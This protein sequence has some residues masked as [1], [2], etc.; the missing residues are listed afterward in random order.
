[1]PTF[2]LSALYVE[3]PAQL[4][5]YEVDARLSDRGSAERAVRDGAAR[6][7][8]AYRKAEAD[9]ADGLFIGSAAGSCDSRYADTDFGTCCTRCARSHR[10]RGLLAYRAVSVERFGTDSEQLVLCVVCVGDERTVKYA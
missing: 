1:M 7:R 9:G 6:Y 3:Q 2:C 10:A 5:K 4:G 8:T